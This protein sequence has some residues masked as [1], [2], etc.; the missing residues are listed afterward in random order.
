MQKSIHLTQQTI[1]LM[2]HLFGGTTN[3][4]CFGTYEDQA[5]EIVNDLSVWVESY[6]NFQNFQNNLPT[7][8]NWVNQVGIELEQES[9]IV[10]LDDVAHLIFIQYD[11]NEINV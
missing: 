6:T 10:I 1:S 4:Q 9:M 2:T 11:D 7:V 8:I 5:S 3:F